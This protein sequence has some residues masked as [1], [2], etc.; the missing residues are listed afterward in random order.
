MLQI[1]SALTHHRRRVSTGATQSG[2]PIEVEDVLECLKL[3]PMKYQRVE[4]LLK[5][6]DDL[7]TM[8]KAFD[9]SKTTPP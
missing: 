2:L 5:N 9:I 6:Y 3:D 4:Q 7:T 1:K 8:L